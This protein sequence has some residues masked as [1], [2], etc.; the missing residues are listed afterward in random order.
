MPILVSLSLLTCGP[1]YTFG[2]DRI[3]VSTQT[4]DAKS[5]IL[6]NLVS[7]AVSKP[8]INAQ[9]PSGVRYYDVING[10]ASGL[11]VEEGGSVQFLWSLRRSNGYFV[12]ASSNYGDE[13]FIYKVGNLSCL[14]YMIRSDYI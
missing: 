4:A 13:P 5:N 3:S 1:S 12:D 8:R 9:L 2:D 14:R 11:S 6:D 10:D 7:D